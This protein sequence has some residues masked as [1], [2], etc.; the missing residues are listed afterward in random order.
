M[1]AVDEMKA[2]EE[3]AGKLEA[4]RRGRFG[5]WV[6]RVT[7]QS[8]HKAQRREIQALLDTGWAAR[9]ANRDDHCRLGCWLPKRA[10]PARVLELGC[11]PGKYVALLNSLGYRVVGVDPYVYPEWDFLRKK[12]AAELIEKVRAEDLPFA[13]RS[14]DHVVCLGAL[15]YFKDPAQAMRECWRVLKP[16]GK[17]IIRTVNRMNL[18]TRRTGRKL[19]PASHNLYT[20]AEL[21]RLVEE[22]RFQ[23][24][25]RFAYGYWPARWTDAWWYFKSVWLPDVAQD[26]LS[27]CLRPDFRVLNCVLASRV[28]P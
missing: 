15:L 9:R 16:Q 22:G 7:M 8:I 28:G 1:N 13:D 3:G 20:M 26:F 10:S 2:A 24:E 5:A 27:F 6:R 18:Y 17:L 4:P 25:E 21:T 23:V 19:D 11:G 14:F 12:T